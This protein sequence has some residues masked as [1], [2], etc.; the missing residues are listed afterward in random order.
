[1]FVAVFQS[2]DL[3]RQVISQYVSLPISFQAVQ[4]PILN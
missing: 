3:D 2:V 4:L 1:M